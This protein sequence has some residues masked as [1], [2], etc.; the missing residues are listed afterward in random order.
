MVVAE[1]GA[2]ESE[3]DLWRFAI[4]AAPPAAHQA[5]PTAAQAWAVLVA[6]GL[7]KAE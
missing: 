7:A 1:A 2:Q 6:N 5:S 3:T 4:P